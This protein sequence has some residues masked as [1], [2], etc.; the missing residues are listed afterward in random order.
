VDF[1]Q[2]FGVTVKDTAH[3]TVFQDD[4]SLVKLRL[5]LINEEVKE[6]NEAVENHDFVETIDALADILYVVYGAG[7]SF[8][9]DL[10]KAFN[11]VHDSNMSKLCKTEDEAKETVDWYKKNDDRYDSPSY[12]KGVTGDYWVVFN[13]S[14]G[15]ILKSVNYTPADFKTM[16]TE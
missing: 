6:L 5:G 1:N 10:D 12:R 15:K 13:Q 11:I 14:S 8:G 3:Q 7:A 2:A 4:Q 16:L 9:I